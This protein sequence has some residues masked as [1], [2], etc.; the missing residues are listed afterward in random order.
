MSRVLTV[1]IAP[2]LLSKAEARAVQLGL[3]RAAYVRSLIEHDLENPRAPSRHRF[4]SEDLVGA[5]RL[6]GE[7]ATNG[8]AREALRRRSRVNRETHR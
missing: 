4:A 7:S 5:F 3:D 8:R 6:G 1:R 2:D